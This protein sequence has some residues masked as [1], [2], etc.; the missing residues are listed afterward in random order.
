MCLIDIDKN[1]CVDDVEREADYIR[2]K[3]ACA[4]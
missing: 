3:V 2:F 4:Q 1:R